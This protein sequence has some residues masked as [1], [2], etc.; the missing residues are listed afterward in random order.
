MILIIEDEKNISNLLKLELT[1]ANYE[2]DQA[3]DGESGLNKALNQDYELILLDLM[4]P[5]INGIEVC[6]QLRLKKQTPIIMLTA[7]DEV[8][9]KVNGLQVGADDYLAKPFAME[10]LLARINA[11]LR[12]VSNQNKSLKY[13][14]GE[15]EIDVINHHVKFKDETITLTTTEFDLLSLLVQNGGNIVTKNDILNKVWG[16]EK[17]VSTNVV[18]VYIRYLRNKLAGINIET[19]R[20]IG[21]RLV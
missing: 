1:H 14:Y 18:E 6:R 21:Y 4:L 16:Y 10:E 8:M 12:R 19:I 9:D 2:C 20:G 17:N 3:F 11:L 15:I 7:R 5:R 13:K